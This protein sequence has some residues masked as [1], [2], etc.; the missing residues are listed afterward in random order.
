MPNNRGARRAGR[1]RGS[2]KK[3]QSALEYLLTY[4]WAILLVA[5]VV[6][7]L[8]LFVFAPSNITPTTCV[9][10]GGTYCQDI[11]FGSNTAQTSMA[12]F[13]TNTQ[14]YAIAY[15]QVTLNYSGTSTTASCSPNLVLE[16]G[17]II[18]NVNVPIAAIALGS[19][20]SGKLVLSAIPCP[21]ADLSTCSSSSRQSYTGT[22]NTHVSPL[23][24]STPSSIAV[25]VGN[26]T[27]AAN[28][29]LDPVN[30]T[31]LLLGNPAQGATVSFTQ[32]NSFATLGPSPTSTDS[33]GVAHAHISSTQTG[34]T[35]ITA[36]FIDD[37]NT[38]LVQFYTPASASVSISPSMKSTV[39]SGNGGTQVLTIDGSSY[40]CSQLPVNLNYN[41]NTQ[42]SYTC[43]SPVYGGTGTQYAATGASGCGASGGASGTFTVGASGTSCNLYC[44][45]Q[46]QYYLT[47]QASPSAGGSVSPSSQ[48]YNSG[49][50]VSISETPNAGYTFTGWTGSG[51]GS[52]TGSS[53]SNTVTMNG[54][55]T[56]TADYQSLISSS[57]TLLSTT[58]QSSSSTTQSTSIS[59]T[60]TYQSSTTTPTTYQ[61]STTVSP[62]TTI[63]TPSCNTCYATTNPGCPGGCPYPYYFSDA[64][65]GALCPGNV[66]SG[67]YSSFECGT[68]PY[69]STSISSTTTIT[70]T[71]N[72]SYCC[73][74]GT[75]ACGNTYSCPAGWSCT[76]ACQWKIYVDP[77][78]G[79]C[80]VEACGGVSNGATYLCQPESSTTTYQSSTTVGSTTTVCDSSFA[81]ATPVLMADGQYKN[82]ESIKPGDAVM[83]YDFKSGTLVPNIVVQVVNFTG[84]HVYLINGALQTDAGELFYVRGQGWVSAANLTV[85]D[86]ITDP[87]SGG[88]ILVSSIKMS[89]SNTTFYDAL[90]T[91]SNNFVAAG[92]LSDFCTS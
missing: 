71:C 21:G 66:C 12:M 11:V 91:I 48:W 31:V 90:G 34:Y 37:S 30:A 18:C 25:T 84:K 89:D 3:A 75:T 83:S 80:A 67:G 77:L 6:A 28:G 38:V 39:C 29:D 78:S 1:A 88:Y 19:L 69:G 59:S 63:F 87:V 52:Y 82:I 56:Q 14:S 47:N 32:S 2:S 8:Y 62:T 74:T 85:G 51:S 46:T 79:I 41:Q 9:F 64:S 49:T 17:A 65:C 44:S 73:S 61:S 15:P 58:T 54:P 4:S 13:L 60:T 27:Q 92:Y 45:Y 22:F 20:V 33:A 53:S 42:H 57:T 70:Q 35:L 72:G 81:G 16:G 55:I 5:I 43:I 76:G 36:N 24:S 26:A 10:T 86:G 68:T 50:Q 7:V 40:T 23:L